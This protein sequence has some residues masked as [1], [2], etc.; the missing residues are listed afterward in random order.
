LRERSK[1]TGVADV[2]V[3][4]RPRLLSDNESAYISEE[5][6]D[7][8]AEREIAHT[9]G[10]PYHPMTQGKVERCRRSIKNPVTFRNYYAPW[11]LEQEIDRLA[12]WYN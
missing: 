1:K 2:R 6:G 7:Y 4:H 8:F 12:Q 9:R 3:H 11:A 10:R 5:P